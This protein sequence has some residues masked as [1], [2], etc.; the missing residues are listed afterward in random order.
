MSMLYIII[1]IRLNEMHYTCTIII[2]DTGY[3]NLSLSHCIQAVLKNLAYTIPC[4]T[5][6]T[7]SI[8]NGTV[9]ALIWNI[10]Y[11]TVGVKA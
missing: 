10:P 8:Q 2:L 9:Q 11:R 3:V 7:L 5:L 4:L 1:L 6:S